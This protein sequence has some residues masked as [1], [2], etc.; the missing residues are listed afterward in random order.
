MDISTLSTQEI[1]THLRGL[2]ME[3]TE[4]ENK[5][6]KNCIL[7]FHYWYGSEVLNEVLKEY[8]FFIDKDRALVYVFRR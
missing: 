7:K 5:Q 1:N 8:D 6:R 3:L 4:E 2:K